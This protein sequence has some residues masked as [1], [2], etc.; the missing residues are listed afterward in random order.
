MSLSSAGV[1]SLWLLGV[2]LLLA[3][4][5]G[6]AVA[7]QTFKVT[8]GVTGGGL[9]MEQDAVPGSRTA[10][11][12]TAVPQIQLARAAAPVGSGGLSSLDETAS[13]GLM[14]V[15]RASDQATLAPLLPGMLLAPGCTWAGLAT[16]LDEPV[17]EHGNR[18]LHLAARSG[19]RFAAWALTEMGANSQLVNHGGETP[20]LAL[21]CRDR[22]TREAMIAQ[23][24]SRDPAL[25]L[26]AAADHIL[27]SSPAHSEQVLTVP[28]PTNGVFGE[29]APQ[30]ARS[31]ED[32]ADDAT[33]EQPV[34][35]L[36]VSFR[37]QSLPLG[38]LSV[39]IRR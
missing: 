13:I 32:G 22:E 28:P 34:L 8:P 20:L 12:G 17:D 24:Q 29:E 11:A 19:N 31:A 38:V 14:D 26:L 39:I 25:A 4:C 16:A 6:A 30:A 35:S 27:T 3:G 2:A 21:R 23:L 5:V 33:E 10:V 1:K 9:R 18:L 7:R 36:R 37:V 15:M